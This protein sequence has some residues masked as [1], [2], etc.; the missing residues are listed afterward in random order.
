MLDLG[1]CWARFE[2]GKEHIRL[3]EGAVSEWA[4]GGPYAFRHQA[5]SDFTRFSMIAEERV[6]PDLV[7]WALMACEAFAN[8]RCSLDHLVWAIGEWQGVISGLTEVQEREI[9]FPIHDSQDKFRSASG[10]NLRGFSSRVLAAVESVQ[11]YNR[12]HPD[13]PPLLGLLSHIDNMNKH[14]L[15]LPVG[16][17]VGAVNTKVS[18]INPPILATEMLRVECAINEVMHNT[19]VLAIVTSKPQR[20]VVT[21][22]AHI[23]LGAALA[24]ANAPN[25]NVRFRNVSVLFNEIAMEVK[26]T[27]E[28]VAAAA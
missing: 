25:T 21:F 2:R 22:N 3:L 16:Q 11:P 5:N 20:T 10:R 12:P 26:A 15:V 18:N 8:L 4:G 17:I 28:G 6:P 13:L 24:I 19:E 14:R 27:I 23:E 7:R 9:C 1:S